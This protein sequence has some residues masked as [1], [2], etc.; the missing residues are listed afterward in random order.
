MENKINGQ[1]NT[2]KMCVRV[3]VGAKYL[4]FMYLCTISTGAL[5][6]LH[7]SPFTFISSVFVLDR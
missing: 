1:W 2:S 3:R 7:V 5:I 4:Y 6:Y